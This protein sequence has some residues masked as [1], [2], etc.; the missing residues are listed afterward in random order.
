M[1]NDLPPTQPTPLA[2]NYPCVSF[3]PHMEQNH[4]S[5]RETTLHTSWFLNYEA[6][7]Q[8]SRV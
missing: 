3:L 5:P 1:H 6:P 7:S 4:F 2:S 8:E